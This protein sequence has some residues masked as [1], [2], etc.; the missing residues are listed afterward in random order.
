MKVPFKNKKF[1]AIPS[2]IPEVIFDDPVLSTGSK[3]FY[4]MLVFMSRQM[5]EIK[6]ST[7]YFKTQM[8]RSSRSITNYIN[9][10]VANKYLRKS[11][12]KGVR[13]LIPAITENENTI[14][15]SFIPPEVVKNGKLSSSEKITFGLLS[16]KAAN[17]NNHF[18]TSVAE[19]TQFMK[20]SR[21]TIYRHLSVLRK[22]QFAAT[23]KSGNMM[24]IR[25]YSTYQKAMKKR[26]SKTFSRR[27]TAPP[28]VLPDQIEQATINAEQINELRSLVFGSSKRT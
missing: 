9:E 13:Y 24:R 26:D 7:Y 11:V 16:Y 21:S 15:S 1:K 3:I 17:S 4:G 5:T 18:E 25:C 10:L 8:S 22:Y 27:K 14:I 19:L 28:D 12:F 20:K 2:I 23:Q 6:A